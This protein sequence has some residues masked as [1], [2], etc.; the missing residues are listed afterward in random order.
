M[1]ITA[2]KKHLMLLLLSVLMVN[3]NALIINNLNNQK[4]DVALIDVEGKQ[5]YS[6][7]DG[8]RTCHVMPV[9]DPYTG[10]VLAATSCYRDLHK[11]PADFVLVKYGI[12]VGSILEVNTQKYP[13]LPSEVAIKISGYTGSIKLDKISSK[14]CE[15]TIK[16]NGFMK[17]ISADYSN[18]F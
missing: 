1:K 17:G 18:C 6:Y 15:I 8:W 7:P 14:D 13:N 2:L 4:I 5:L 3:V 16:N 12:P 11:Y 9:I 10:A